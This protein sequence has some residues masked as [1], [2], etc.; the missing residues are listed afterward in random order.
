MTLRSKDPAQIRRLAGALVRHLRRESAEFPVLFRLLEEKGEKVLLPVSKGID[1][2]KREAPRSLGDA[3]ETAGTDPPDES[4]TKDEA[5]KAETTESKSLPDIPS[6]KEDDSHSVLSE[7]EPKPAEEIETGEEPR[8]Q[9]PF[10]REFPDTPAEQRSPE[11]EAAPYYVRNAGLVLLHPHLPRLFRNLDLLEGKK[12]REEAARHRAV[13]L[14]HWLATGQEGAPEY[15]MLLAKHLCAMPFEA[16]LEREIELEE[17]EKQE[18]YALLEAVIG[19]WT[20]LKHTSPEGLRQGFLQRD[21][22]LE[23]RSDG[24]RLRVEQRTMDILIDRLPWSISL[25]KLPWMPEMLA[26]EWV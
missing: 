19:Q 16:P 8:T 15:D 24:W 22:K 26:V 17:R 23:R 2:T 13:H 11:K 6:Q 9:E 3:A 5:G 20:A 25:I 10:E 12:F 18:C 7:K 1:T 4:D 14:L 21:G